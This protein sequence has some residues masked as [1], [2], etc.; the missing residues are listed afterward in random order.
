[1]CSPFLLFTFFVLIHSLWVC[2]PFLLFPFFVLMVT[3]NPFFLVH[4]FCFNSFN[5]NLTHREV[6]WKFLSNVTS[7]FIYIFSYLLWHVLC[8]PLISRIFCISIKSN[9]SYI[10][11]KYQYYVYWSIQSSKVKILYPSISWLLIKQIKDWD[12]YL[13]LCNEQ[14]H[15]Q[16]QIFF[17][18]QFCFIFSL[19]FPIE[20]FIESF[21]PM[22]QV[23][24]YTY[25]LI[26]FDM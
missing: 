26:C 5:F 4:L 8:L 17:S 19:L 14:L 18:Y 15:R 20:R 6:Y 9:S 7:M 11:F 12:H 23:C 10:S 24:S 13:F 1:V 16:V 22:W 25:F 2:P 3:P 21:S